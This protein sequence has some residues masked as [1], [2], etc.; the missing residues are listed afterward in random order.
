[1]AKCLGTCT[2]SCLSLSAT[3]SFSLEE[4]V[5]CEE[6]DFIVAANCFCPRSAD[7]EGRLDNVAP[8]DW[9]IQKISYSSLNVC[10]HFNLPK[11]EH[12]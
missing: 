12:S 7:I 4:S 8:I 9:A 11:T 3:L 6:I 5:C 10:G 2:S 1:M